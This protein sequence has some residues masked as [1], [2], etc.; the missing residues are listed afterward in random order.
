MLVSILHK[1]TKLSTTSTTTSPRLSSESEATTQNNLKP[2]FL[3]NNPAQQQLFT[4]RFSSLN[5]VK[6]KVNNMHEVVSHRGTEFVLFFIFPL[7]SFVFSL[8][9]I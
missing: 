5:Q 9:V 2:P 4:F 1:L 7:F 8:Y 6:K 3:E